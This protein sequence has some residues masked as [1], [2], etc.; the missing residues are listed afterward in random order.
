MI[1]INEY[2]RGFYKGTKNPSL[3]AMR[4][5]MEKYD[6]FEKKMK[7][8]HI[9]GTNGKG[10]CTEM[11]SSI[12]V[13]QGYKVGKY[14]SPHLIRFNERI[15]I[16]GI[17][18]SD[19]ELLKLIEELNPIIDE[20]NK[21]QYDRITLF[22]LQTM[23]TLLYFY[24]NNVD[25]AVLE[26]GLGGLY[27]CTNI[28][29]KPLVSIITSIGF[30]HMNIL[31]NSLIEIAEQKA[32]IIKRKSNTIIF[33]NSLEI[34]NV[35]IEICKEKE[36]ELHIAENSMIKKYR[37]DNKFQYFDYKDK[38][39]IAINLKGK[40]Q[41]KNAVL[42]IETIEILKKL[43]YSISD[44]NLKKGFKNVIHK[45]RMECLNEFPTIIYDGAHN[46]QAI[47]NFQNMIKIYYEGK[48]KIYIIAILK[49]KDY[50]RILKIL[51]EDTNGYFV[52]T[53]GSNKGEFATCDELF[54]KM[55]EYISA[56]KICKKNL[57]KAIEDA[58]NGDINSYNFVVGSFYI[59]D[60]VEEIIKKE[61]NID[62]LCKL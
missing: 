41:I 8:I 6:N 13:S 54:N 59:Y 32:G 33:K 10:S 43:G 29:T 17:N 18:I 57:K 44:N 39:N 35:F 7:F 50:D 28:I 40:V 60:I 55:K 27:D 36:N 48:N 26:T 5:F 23:M 42:C 46:E 61:K 2:L 45:G 25:I 24:R 47:E 34:D 4:F 3:N 38:K 21:K 1:D 49:S 56:E 12:L 53:S 19:E 62:N 9:A 52:L 37:Y 31:G 14:I 51:A 30:D 58:M 15:S 22:E 11:I 20:Y 16:N